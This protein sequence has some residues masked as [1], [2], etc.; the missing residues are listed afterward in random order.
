MATDNVSS[1]R[2]WYEEVW[3]QSRAETIDELLADD[4][5]S[6]SEAGA[7]RGKD[8]FKQ[9]QHSVFLGAFPDLRLAVD[10]IV[11]EGDLVVVRWTA[12][13]THTGDSLG[14]PAIGRKI[15]APGTT[16]IRFRDGKMAE[17]WDF[18]NR[19]G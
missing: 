12:T 10:A 8:A 5:V 3:N 2:R 1:A 14:F 19:S 17:G 18:W 6:Y 16:W 15:V 4:C 9:Q 11:A 7:L 13:G